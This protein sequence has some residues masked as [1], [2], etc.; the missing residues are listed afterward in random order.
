MSHV[1]LGQEEN[2]DVYRYQREYENIV[3]NELKF[4]NDSPTTQYGK[5]NVYDKIYESI[6]RLYK[7]KEADFESTLR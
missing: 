6:I 2:I 5:L 3:A 1:R 7:S 4:I